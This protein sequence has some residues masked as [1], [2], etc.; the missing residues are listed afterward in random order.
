MHKVVGDTAG[1]GSFIKHQLRFHVHEFV[2]GQASH[3]FDGYPH[4]PR[5][6]DGRKAR[7]E[8]SS[9]SALSKHFISNFVPTIT[10]NACFMKL[11]Q[12]H[13]KGST[14]QNLS[15]YC[16]NSP[17]D[18]SQSEYRGFAIEVTRKI[19]EKLEYRNVRDTSSL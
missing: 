14:C 18:P 15:Q 7:N 12:V 17:N 2:A 6:S 1:S 10:M 16:W 13:M 9:P 5:H 11:S 3:E 4:K 19:T 8:T